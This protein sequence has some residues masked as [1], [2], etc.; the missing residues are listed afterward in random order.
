MKLC[1]VNGEFMPFDEVRIPAS[2]HIIL[3]GIGV[4]DL[5]RTYNRRPMMMTD[6]LNR[7]IKSASSLGIEQKLTLDQM[8]S[9]VQEG[10][11]KMP[12]DGEVLVNFYITGGD[13]FLDDCRFPNP[14]YFVIFS[15]LVPPHKSRYEKGV[16][17]YPLDR[18]RLMPSAKSIDYTAALAKNALDPGALEVL[19]CPGGVITEAGHSSFFLVK[20]ASVITAPDDMVLSGTV[21]S[22]VI[23]LLEE[24]HIPLELRPPRTDELSQ[25]QEAFITGSV[26]EI[27]PVIQI[28]S[29]V[30]GEGRPGPFTAKITELY[31][32]NI[33]RYVE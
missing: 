33:Y 28:G 3:R 25:A 10:I 23:K 9:I 5:V 30:I 27:M 14:R 32:K 22:I 16:R 8:K 1:Y 17:L 15:D 13:D 4:F 20:N 19:Y 29:S 12:G 11:G 18:A 2:D 31:R 7:L 26:K 6:H 21:R 24:N